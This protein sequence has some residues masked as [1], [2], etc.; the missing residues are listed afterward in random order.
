MVGRIVSIADVFDALT[1][2]CPYK[3]PYPYPVEVTLEIIKKGRG[4]HFDPD[5]A[6]VF[7]KNIDQ[8][9]QIRASFNSLFDCLPYVMGLEIG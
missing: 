8:V 2:R 3:E 5:V 9:L 1:S 6:D 7:L 4:Q